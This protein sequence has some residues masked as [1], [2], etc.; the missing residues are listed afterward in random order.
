MVSDRVIAG[1][2][3]LG[4]GELLKGLI[5]CEDRRE[6]LVFVHLAVCEGVRT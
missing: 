3:D 1:D 6:Q 5:W 2:E 4:L